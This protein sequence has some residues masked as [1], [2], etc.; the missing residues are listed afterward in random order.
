[1][2]AGVS[3]EV[4]EWLEWLSWVVGADWPG[5]DE[6]AMRRL[7]DAWTAM[8][9]ALGD[10]S[11]NG[12]Q[13]ADLVVTALDAADGRAFDRTWSAYSGDDEAYLSKLREACD[14][15]AKLCEGC[16]EDIEYAKYTF[17]VM[18]ILL[19]IDIAIM[20]SAAAATFGGS[21][22]EI[23]VEEGLT[24]LA[25][26]RVA[27]MVVEKI[28]ER[29]AEKAA[30]FSVKQLVKEGVKS[31]LKGE[32][33]DFGAQLLMTAQ[34]DEKGGW[35]FARTGNSVLNAGAGAVLGGGAD[36]LGNKTGLGRVVF[37]D[38]LFGQT[39]K[40]AVVGGAT[41]FAVGAVTGEPASWHDVAEGATGGAA[42]GAIGFARGKAEEWASSPPHGDHVAIPDADPPETL[43]ASSSRPATDT[44]TVDTSATVDA[45]RPPGTPD[46]GTTSATGVVAHG[47][48]A[49]QVDSG[50]TTTGRTE[51]A[52]STTHAAPDRTRTAAEPTRHAGGDSSAAER[53][54]RTI[55]R[56]LAPNP[57]E[58]HAGATHDDR[59][60]QRAVGGAADR[61]RPGGAEQPAVRHG[62][63]DHAGSRQGGDG[64]ASVDR[65]RPAA[66]DG[67]AAADGSRQAGGPTTDHS[68]QSGP[69]DTRHAADRVRTANETQ[70]S[71]AREE[72]HDRTGRGS[73]TAVNRIDA[74]LN[75]PAR[76]TSNAPAA[77][78]DTTDTTGTT[79]RRADADTPG[80]DRTAVPAGPESTQDA[81]RTSTPAHV[82]RR[83]T[84]GR[85]AAEGP[86][87]D[88]DAGR[89]SV[90]DRA[91][92]EDRDTASAQRPTTSP[93][94]I[95][96]LGYDPH[97]PGFPDPGDGINTVHHEG[98]EWV[99]L[100]DDAGWHRVEF[101][102]TDERYAG[103]G[104]AARLKTFVDKY[105]HGHDGR[106]AEDLFNEAR[107]KVDTPIPDGRKSEFESMSD[108][109]RAP[110]DAIRNESRLIEPDDTDGTHRVIQKVFPKEDIPQYVSGLFGGITGFITKLVD[111][112][113]LRTPRDIVEGL[114][115]DYEETPYSPDQGEI[116]AIRM[117]V[118][119]QQAQHEIVIPSSQGMMRVA[120]ERGDAT[121]R[122]LYD[123]KAPFSGSGFSAE[124]RK[125]A[126]ELLTDN[127]NDTHHAVALQE[128]AEMW[129][130]TS[131]GHEELFAVYHSGTWQSTAPSA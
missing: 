101:R 20:I 97:R 129:R 80:P 22:V 81:A 59:D 84:P 9:T 55:E 74:V 32:L 107:G 47:S 4:P 110:L 105:F 67:G 61:T 128:G 36:L 124:A 43:L 126:P 44:S 123:G 2:G 48:A 91:A 5:G 82:D 60:R 75:P 25:A 79:A 90:E 113:H 69:D 3:Y 103:K 94:T 17:I 104:F 45:A 72:V 127:Q 120:G 108:A 49:A 86:R 15:L 24:Q 121:P 122:K 112:T 1:M 52:R 6:D 58:T 39:V 109:D 111:V 29:T 7:S 46:T 100:E 14:G 89:T 19:A 42:G 13:A 88:S 116:Y 106:T 57:D 70:A 68:R 114:R 83:S 50:A 125:G 78:S 93:E 64:G 21:L 35:N 77:D 12:D 26:R 62:G 28:A 76:P 54:R 41:P 71:P 98:R 16:A 118:T 38:N 51:S 56:P 30:E 119:E 11:D 87:D 95:E 131:D 27:T 66:D 99:R 117:R 40:G 102:S 34:G 92:P 10:A 115:L 33:P 65:S 23:A 31:T 130:I 8:G 96:K 63:G 53:P 18:L 85:D 73:T 37:G